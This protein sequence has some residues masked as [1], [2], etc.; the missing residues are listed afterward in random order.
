MTSQ[1]EFKKEAVSKAEQD[2]TKLQL[3]PEAKK[4]IAGAAQVY[5]KFLPISELALKGFIAMALRDFQVQEKVD[6]ATIPQLP[7]EKRDRYNQMI[8]KI[9]LAKLEKVLV[10]PG[11][12]ALLKE[13]FEKS[14]EFAA[15][16]MG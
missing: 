8:A 3:T 6:A 1:L 7:K 4:I 2:Y 10:R 9:L 12:K 13:G 16:M 15:K 14:L 11:Q 5:A